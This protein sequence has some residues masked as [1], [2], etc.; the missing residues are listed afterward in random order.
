[1]RAA[2]AQMEGDADRAAIHA[3]PALLFVELD[4]HRGQVSGFLRTLGL[5]PPQLDLIRYYRGV[6]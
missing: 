1:M 5:T 4:P 2:L 6:D 3:K